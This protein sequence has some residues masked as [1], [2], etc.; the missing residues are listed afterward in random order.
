MNY[1]KVYD[2]QE[3]CYLEP[4]YKGYEGKIFDFY[5]GY[6]GGLT[7]RCQGMQNKGFPNGYTDESIITKGADRF[8]IIINKEL[9]K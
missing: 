6:N 5:L 2:K 9:L 1:F 4:I 8:E 7:F 3:K